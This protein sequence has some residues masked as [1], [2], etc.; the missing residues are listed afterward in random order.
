MIKYFN[1]VTLLSQQFLLKF[2]VKEFLFSQASHKDEH[3]PSLQ[4]EVEFH[5][6]KSCQ[7]FERMSDSLIN[8]RKVQIETVKALFYRQNSHENVF[9]KA[10]VYSLDLNYSVLSGTIAQM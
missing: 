4:H 10:T 7:N 1:F 5:W 8:K 9:C 3:V 2:S 6:L